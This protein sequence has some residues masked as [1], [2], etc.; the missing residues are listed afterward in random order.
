VDLTDE[1]AVRTLFATRRPTGVINCAAM[2]DVD[3]CEAC[4][5]RAADI[6]QTAAGHLAA[7]AAEVGSSF[8]QVSTDAVF[9]GRGGPYAEED[10]PAPL[11]VYATSKLAGEREVR[12]AHAGAVVVRTNMFG[13]NPAPA[14]GL[15][16]WILGR[17]EAGLAVPAFDDVSFT[18]LLANDLASILLELCDARVG[19]LFHAAAPNVYTKYDFARLICEAFGHPSGLVRPAR[20]ADA[21]LTAARPRH[22]AL[23]AD[24]M[25]R[26]LNRSLPDVREG[27]ARLLALRKSG[28]V[29][30]L[31]ASVER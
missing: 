18:P 28:W 5:A 6:N 10:R 26:L 3:G 19:G 29:A 12:A 1:N 25:C 7:S 16:G 24:K 23:R 14:Q 30:T 9:D 20:L 11:N 15:V 13:W 2:T 8:V 4:P 22:T 27:V 31:T 21:P 17:L